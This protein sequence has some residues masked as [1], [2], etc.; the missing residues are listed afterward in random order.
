[1]REG[2]NMTKKTK[3]DK[4]IYRATITFEVYISAKDPD[5]A[6]GKMLT[7]D[8]AKLYA[9]MNYIPNSIVVDQ[10]HYDIL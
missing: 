4:K 1:L 10:K 2:R 3:N 6:K 9:K 8:K 5:D 7:I